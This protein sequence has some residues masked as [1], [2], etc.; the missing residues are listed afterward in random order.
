MQK[1]LF[2]QLV[3]IIVVLLIPIIPFVIIG[4]LPGER[5]LSSA[6]ESALLFGVTGATLL[7]CDLV[8]PVPSSVVGTLV[9]ARLGFFPGLAAVWLGLMAGQVL[10]YLFGRFTLRRLKGDFPDIPTSL[11]VFLSRPVPILAEAVALAAGASAMSPSRFVGVCGAGNLVYAAVLVG[12]AAAL[13]PDALLGPGVFIPMFLPVIGWWIW[14]V[15]TK[16]PARE[17]RVN[18]T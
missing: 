14:R 8:L 1:K 17:I 4:E 11:V 15:V 9:G 13:L 10:G 16:R 12:N 7:L 5:W 2:R 18:E 6:D 3:T